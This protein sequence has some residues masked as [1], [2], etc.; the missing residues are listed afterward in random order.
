MKRKLIP[1]V[2]LVAAAAIGGILWSRWS[3]GP[4]PNSVRVSGNIELTQ[5]DIAF[6]I[7]GRIVELPVE[8]GIHVKK[9]QLIARIDQEQLRSQRGREQAVVAIAEAQIEQAKTAIQWQKE[10]VARDIELRRADVQAAQARMAELQA[11]PRSQEIAQ[12]QAVL[13]E[14]RTQYEQAS[15]DWERAQQLFANDD[16]SAQQR[17]QSQTKFQAAAAAV[18]RAE[19]QVVL[20]QEGTRHEQIEA[21]RAQVER[22]RAALRLAEANRIET[23]RREQELTARRS[24]ADRARAQLSIAQ[25]QFEYTVVT[26]SI[27]GVVLVK[28]AELGETVAP[29]RAIITI[30]DIDHPWVRGFIGERHLGRVKIGDEVKVTSDSYPGKTYT[31]RLS[32]IAS[33]AEFTPKQIQTPEERVKLVY[34]VKVEIANPNGELKNNMPVA[35]VIPLR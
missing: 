22:A 11:G 1:V 20:L 27:D 12:A 3:H 35:A 7:A 28:S 33:E 30:G 15:K 31:G 21:Q 18:K 32:F 4:E 17:D 13:S 5:V 16:I 29:G 19:Q 23:L 9:G 25:G 10:T 34:R 26:S 8:E 6:K 14:A 24:D 2:V